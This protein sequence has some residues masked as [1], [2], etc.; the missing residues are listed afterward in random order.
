MAVSY[1]TNT[2]FETA[3]TTLV[4]TLGNM[5]T[6]M[7]TDGVSPSFGAVYSTHEGTVGMTMP[8]LTIGLTAADGTLPALKSSPAGPVVDIM[9]AVALRVHLGYANVYHD[10]IKFWRL[11]NSVI[12][13]FESHRDLETTGPRIESQFRVE[14][15]GK[16]RDTATLGGT[17]SF[18][19]RITEAYVAL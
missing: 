2:A 9:I 10:E 1:G 7:T 4:T 3:R 14:A 11:A 17:V 16:F 5:L 19:I 12:N 8:A 13:W 18:V 15:G 6:Q